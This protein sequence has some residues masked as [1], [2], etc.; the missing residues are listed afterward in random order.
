MLDVQNAY[1]RFDVGAYILKHILSAMLA[2]S[3]I[4]WR[5]RPDKTIAVDWFVKHQFQ[6]HAR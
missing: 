5:Q 6:M 1:A 2:R 3:P 4:K